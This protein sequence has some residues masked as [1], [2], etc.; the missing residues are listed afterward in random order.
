MPLEVQ[1]LTCF[2]CKRFNYRW[3]SEFSLTW[4]CSPTIHQGPS[5]WLVANPSN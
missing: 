4:S 3:N 2:V 1:I 5:I